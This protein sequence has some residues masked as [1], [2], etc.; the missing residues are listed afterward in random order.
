MSTTRL[1]TLVAA[2]TVL[3]LA[4][5]GIASAQGYADFRVTMTG[6]AGPIPKGQGANYVTTV[7][8]LG[9]ES[10]TASSN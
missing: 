3:T 7:Q 6:D 2:V 4:F 10:G 1:A 5:P 9:T 8:N